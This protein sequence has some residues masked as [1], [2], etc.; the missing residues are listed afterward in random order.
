MCFVIGFNAKLAH[1]ENVFF[2]I[3]GIMG[4]FLFIAGYKNWLGPSKFEFR[5]SRGHRGKLL[6]VMHDLMPLLSSS[7]LL[8][9]NERAESIY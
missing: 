8:D 6:L 4:N 2:R 7:L 3:L 1:Q 5:K 9:M